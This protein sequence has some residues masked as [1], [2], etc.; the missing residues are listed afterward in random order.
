M[1][2]PWEQQDSPLEGT[3]GDLPL[4]GLLAELL[5]ADNFTDQDNVFDESSAPAQTP[6]VPNEAEPQPEPECYSPQT[7]APFVFDLEAIRYVPTE[8]A[9]AL[10][11]LD[12]AEAEPVELRE[13]E[14]AIGS[15]ELT[16]ASLPETEDAGA[17]AAGPVSSAAPAPPV[18]V[19]FE[20]ESEPTADAFQPVEEAVERELAPPAADI[21]AAPTAAGPQQPEMAL[22]LAPLAPFTAFDAAAMDFVLVEPSLVNVEKF[23]IRDGGGP[24]KST[25]FARPV[26]LGRGIFDLAPTSF[27][28]APPAV[29][30]PAEAPP[31][32]VA[33]AMP[34]R[35]SETVPEEACQSEAA[36]LTEAGEP[37]PSAA[38]E[39]PEAL[40]L[41]QPGQPDEDAAPP[42]PSDLGGLLSIIDGEIEAA[43][44]VSATQPEDG[45][46]TFERFVA[47]RLAEA[48]FALHMTTVREVE[49]V[50]RVT[51]VPG[52]PDCLCG[53]INLRGEILP[54]LDLKVLLGQAPAESPAT[55][56]LVVTQPDPSEPPFA[57]LVDELGGVALVDPSA[58]ETNPDGL[59]AGLTRHILGAA[60]H[61]G[62]RVLL[63][64][65]RTIL[66]AVDQ[67]EAAVA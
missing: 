11:S 61:R 19:T 29:E 28:D 55:G 7:V 42:L 20:V 56:R 38:P 41:K 27:E 67:R 4:A 62:R 59:D 17:V 50:A 43:P 8:A 33:E 22:E 64:N 65:P 2:E 45:A 16:R 63:L 10:E 31:E 54:L 1:K 26:S 44:A 14:V 18:E 35:V 15:A 12:T 9:P 25:S 21:L 57:L 47:F 66:A 13:N 39:E 37:V 40:L 51:P 6:E 49:R 24:P 52:G 58:I 30:A 23:S 32:P 5:A 48:S 3:V 36:A 60:S 34:E 46:R 53:L